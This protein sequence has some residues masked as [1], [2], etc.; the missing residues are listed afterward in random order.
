MSN[1]DFD[2][3]VAL[4]QSPSKLMHAKVLEGS[5]SLAIAW[6]GGARGV[7]SLE[8]MIKSNRHFSKL[9]NPDFFNKC[10]IIDDGWSLGWPGDISIG[11]DQLFI[12]A[13][14]QL[15]LMS[16][17]MNNEQFRT[18]LARNHLSQDLAAVNLGITQRTISKYAKGHSKIPRTVQIACMAIDAGLIP[19]R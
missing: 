18:W 11:W 5:Y 1:E 7:I 9:S 19:I 2:R 15:A 4:H 6:V 17:N 10:A 8:D 3:A 12:I 16:M 14:D 13:E